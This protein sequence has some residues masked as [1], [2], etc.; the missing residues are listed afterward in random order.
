MTLHFPRALSHG[1]LGIRAEADPQQLFRELR[2]AIEG[3]FS[4]YETQLNNMETAL[5]AV[6]GDRLSGRHCST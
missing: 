6:A 5:N 4:D 1:C 2:A 3:R